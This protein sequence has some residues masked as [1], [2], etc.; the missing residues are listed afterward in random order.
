[1]WVILT[2]K[3]PTKPSPPKLS[4]FWSVPWPDEKFGKR[5]ILEQKKNVS[6]YYDEDTIAEADDYDEIK[7]AD[8]YYTTLGKE[9]NFNRA[10]RILY[11]G[12]SIRVFPHEFSELSNAKMKYFISEGL[13]DFVAEG[14]ASES[15]LGSIT[16]ELDKEG[17][18][19][20]EAAL[21]DG[22]NPEQA[23]ATAMGIDLTVD[24]PEFPPLGWY[25]VKP[26][27][28]CVFAYEEELQEDREK[29]IVI[30]EPKKS[31]RKGALR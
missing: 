28:G 26:E 4:L 19:I 14:A 5:Q 17:K 2:K 21:L 25:K 11:A 29:P 7:N 31:K 12:E 30:D 22:C 9:G 20:Y 16:G 6:L 1:M 3:L 27:Y 18:T 23:M 15:L 24:D 8:V 13:Y 10:R